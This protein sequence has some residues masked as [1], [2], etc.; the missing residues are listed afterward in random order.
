MINELYL[1]LSR[2]LAVHVEQTIERYVANEH[3]AHTHLLLCTCTH[4]AQTFSRLFTPCCSPITLTPLSHHHHSARAAVVLRVPRR[5]H[6]RGE[7]LGPGRRHRRRHQDRQRRHPRAH[8][9]GEWSCLLCMQVLL[10]VRV[11]CCFL[12][13]ATSSPVYVT[14][15]VTHRWSRTSP[16]P[17]ERRRSPS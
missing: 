3:H 15:T 4:M 10:L 5:R 8:G 12:V 11:F 9:G 17:R 13:F 14:I 7:G 6:P 1:D 2:L 16:P